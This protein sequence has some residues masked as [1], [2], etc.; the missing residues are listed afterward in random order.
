MMSP[1]FR[2]RPDLL[3]RRSL[4]AVM[5]LPAGADDV[6]TI[7]GTGV[8]AWELLDT[9]RTVEALTDLLASRFGADRR[10]V[11]PDLE[12]LISE[13]RELGALEVAADSGGPAAG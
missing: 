7:A 5:L 8:D 1:A 13:L 2:R 4:D 11:E 12:A 9:W 10:V 3:W 6:I